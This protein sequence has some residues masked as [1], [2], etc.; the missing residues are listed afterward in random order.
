MTAMVLLTANSMHEPKHSDSFLD[1][2]LVEIGLQKVRQMVME[3]ESKTLQSFQ[4]TFIEIYHYSQQRCAK[5]ARLASNADNS[6]SSM[7]T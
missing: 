1:N 7:S 2:H 3:S 4:A 5:A 6:S